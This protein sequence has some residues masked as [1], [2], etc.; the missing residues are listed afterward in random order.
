MTLDDLLDEICGQLGDQVASSKIDRDELTIEIHKDHLLA[1]MYTLRDQLQFEQL[2]DIAGVDYSAYKETEWETQETTAT[3][4]SRGRRDSVPTENISHSRFAVVYHLLSLER[5]ARIRVKTPVSENDVFLPS[6][7]EVWRSAD[8]YEREVFDL[9]GLVFTGH[10]D[11]RRILTDYG[12]IGHP[13]RKDFPLSG[14]VEMRFDA[15]EQR[16]VYEPVEIDPR[17]T[18]PKVVR[19]DNRYD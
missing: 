9:F 1:A 16:V 2:T 7:I 12:F 10:Y 19:E 11:L 5:N 8:W 6:I 15:D 13:F 14:H 3:G 17:V 18:V 4:F